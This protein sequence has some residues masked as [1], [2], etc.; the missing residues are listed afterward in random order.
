MNMMMLPT[1]ILLVLSILACIAII[2]FIIACWK[3][4]LKK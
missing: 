2:S 1:Y 3:Y 4:I